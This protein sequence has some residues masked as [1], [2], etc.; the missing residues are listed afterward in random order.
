MPVGMLI[1]GWATGRIGPSP[2]FLIGGTL[3]ALAGLIALTHPAI[4]E[5]D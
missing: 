4:R 1:A 5:L 2:V 3:T